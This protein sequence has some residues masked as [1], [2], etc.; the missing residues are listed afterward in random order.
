MQFQRDEI[1]KNLTE[2]GLKLIEIEI[3]NREKWT[4]ETVDEIL[5]IESI[6]RSLGF[7]AQVIFSVDSVSQPERKKG[8]QVWAVA[9]S[10]GDKSN[11]FLL[12]KVI[13]RKPERYIYRTC[14]ITANKFSLKP[15]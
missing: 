3:P 13:G 4:N 14:K 15:I 11:D 2:H 1:I 6:W 9:V 7:R 12:K 5:T 8:E 10:S